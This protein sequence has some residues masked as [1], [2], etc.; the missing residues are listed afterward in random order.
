MD[1]A[2]AVRTEAPGTAPDPEMDAFREEVGARIPQGDALGQAEARIDYLL[3]RCATERERIA[4][5]NATAN[6]RIAM[7]QDHAEEEA[8]RY[9]KRVAY[10]EALI[11]AHIPGDSSRFVQLYGKKSLSLPNG[12][13]GFRSSPAT[14]QIHDMDEAVQW[15]TRVGVHVTEKTIRTVPKKAIMDWV[16]NGTGELPDTGAIELLDGSETFY[17]KA[18][19]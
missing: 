8:K 19:E 17:V 18:G 4:R 14:V 12:T 15:A 7:I 16:K 9:E 11:H 3:E 2:T 10:V 6:A 1:G 5:V 13:V